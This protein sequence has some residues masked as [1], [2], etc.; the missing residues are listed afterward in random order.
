MSLRVL[1]LRLLRMVC[2][3]VTSVT[4]SIFVAVNYDKPVIDF[5]CGISAMMCLVE[6]FQQLLDLFDSESS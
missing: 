3:M 6:A 2:L 1:V 5:W 4:L